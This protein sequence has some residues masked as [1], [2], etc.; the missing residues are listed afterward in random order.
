MGDIYIIPFGPASA[1]AK[2][3]GTGVAVDLFGV[4]EVEIT[5]DETSKDAYAGDLKSPVMT[6]IF[7]EKVKVT[8]KCNMMTASLARYLWGG[9]LTATKLS[10]IYHDADLGAIAAGALTLTKAARDENMAIVWMR[11]ATTGAITILTVAATP[12][13]PAVDEY[14]ITGT[15]FTTNAGNDGNLVKIWYAYDDAAAAG[16]TQQNVTSNYNRPTIH[17]IFQAHYGDW[18]AKTESGLYPLEI[19]SLRLS[20]P[21]GGILEEDFTTFTIEGVAEVDPWTES[22]YIRGIPT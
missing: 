5:T 1:V 6:H 3:N 15:A 17:A 16:Y 20:V 10:A 4:R 21:K 13:S 22:T 9:D 18:M 8:L 14:E 7:K 11:D 19:P 2:V 12:G